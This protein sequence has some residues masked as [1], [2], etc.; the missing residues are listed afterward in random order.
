[1]TEPVPSRRELASRACA[2]A[3]VREEVARLNLRHPLSS[4]SRPALSQGAPTLQ[5]VLEEV[6]TGE[7]FFFRQSEHFQFLTPLLL[8]VARR[9]SVR[10]WSAGCST[11][12]EAH[13]IAAWAVALTGN[14][15]SVEVLGTDV[16]AS[17]LVV[18][19]AG[20]YGFWSM[21]SHE[22]C[23][24]PVAEPEG[25]G[26]RVLPAVRRVTRFEVHNLLDPRPPGGGGFD[27]IFCRNVLIYLTPLAA[28]RA[29]Q[30]LL[31]A[32]RP[33][34]VLVFAPVDLGEIPPQL[35]TLGPAEL[36]CYRRA[37]DRPPAALPPRRAPPPASSPV[38]LAEVPAAPRPPA[39]PPRLIERHLAAISVA[40]GG[41]TRSALR[42]LDELSAE[43]PSYLP[44]ML[45]RALL[46]VRVGE[47]VAACELACEVLERLEHLGVDAPIEGPVPLSAAYYRA[48]ALALLERA[49]R[50]R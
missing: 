29:V 28:E 12:E 40:E 34:G 37:C 43:S 22:P 24:W 4:L 33:R 7:T 27:F 19:S 8:D 31:A 50:K 42:L 39:F 15:A 10:A 48:A 44:A 17:R 5:D 16:V 49:G 38:A 46:R 21:R 32:L 18:A 20:Q 41:R 2:L 25:D 9:G 14:Q 36:S 3:G 23:P 1:M 13:S 45:S 30:N 47:V 11:G 35:A 6:T 26:F